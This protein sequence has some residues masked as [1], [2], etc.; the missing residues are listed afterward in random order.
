LDN[1]GHRI[2][3]AHDFASLLVDLFIRGREMVGKSRCNFSVNMNYP[4]VVGNDPLPNAGLL[5]G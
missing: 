4:F 2:D 1:V 5:G 3:V